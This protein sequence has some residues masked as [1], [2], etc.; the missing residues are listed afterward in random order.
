MTKLALRRKANILLTARLRGS[1]AKPP[2]SCRRR[3]VLSAGPVPVKRAG[4]YW[5][6]KQ[7]VSSEGGQWGPIHFSADTGIGRHT[8][9]TKEHSTFPF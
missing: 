1:S 5:M 3:Q 4:I 2:S 7:K 6:A 8:K 9:T